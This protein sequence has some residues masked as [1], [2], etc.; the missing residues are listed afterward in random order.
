MNINPVRRYRFDTFKVS[1]VIEDGPS[2]RVSNSRDASV[3]MRS[4]VETVDANV[5]HFIA[6][7][8]NSKNMITGF[9]VIHTGGAASSVV[10]PKIVFRALLALD[11]VGFF[12]CHNHPSGDPA[13]SREDRDVTARLLRGSKILGIRMLDHVILGESDYFSFADAGQLE[14]I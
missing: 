13:P 5:E 2:P 9:K 4:V 12:V 6:F 7:A 1:L 8:V 14:E 10:D 3:F 11:A